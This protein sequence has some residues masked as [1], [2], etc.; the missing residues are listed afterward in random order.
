MSFLALGLFTLVPGSVA[1]LL[2]SFSL[3]SRKAQP[4]HISHTAQVLNPYFIYS[5]TTV[6]SF[7]IS[8]F[9]RHR[10]HRVT[11]VDT[12][13]PGWAATIFNSL[14][15]HQHPIVILTLADIVSL[16]QP[17]MDLSQ[18]R[19]ECSFLFVPPPYFKVRFGSL[20]SFLVLRSV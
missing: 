10:Y 19:P 18:A 5:H 17:C 12:D 4:T 15:P 9:T 16:T 14:R 11:F 7:S 3:P 1:S 6:P 13:D 20:L 2:Q 8:R